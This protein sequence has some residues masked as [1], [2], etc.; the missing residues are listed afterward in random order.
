MLRALKSGRYLS[1]VFCSWHI[2]VGSIRGSFR[3]C[4]AQPNIREPSRPLL[5]WRNC[6]KLQNLRFI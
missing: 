3:Y 5:S 2:Y 1:K 4:N 6:E